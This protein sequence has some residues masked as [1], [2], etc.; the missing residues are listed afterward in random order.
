MCVNAYFLKINTDRHTYIHI[1]IIINAN[2]YNAIHALTHLY[3]TKCL[4]MITLGT[5]VAVVVREVR[6]ISTHS[7]FLLTDLVIINSAQLQVGTWGGA[8]IWD[9]TVII[10]S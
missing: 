6:K 8:V 2:T 3:H 4:L 1:P 7:I 5:V 10:S 9:T